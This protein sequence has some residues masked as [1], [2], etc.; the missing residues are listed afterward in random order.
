MKKYFMLIAVAAT[1][2][3]V[4]CKKAREVEN[5]T[6]QPGQTTAIDDSV[7]APVLFG[8]NMAAV[9]SP[10]MTKGVGAIDAW[11]GG[12][13]QPLYI[14][15][16]EKGTGENAAKHVATTWKGVGA[17]EPAADL[18]TPFIDNVAATAPN[19]G[20]GSRDA[21][22]V[23]NKWATGANAATEPYY[24]MENKIYDFYGYYVDDA[25][26]YTQA[27][28][29]AVIAPEPEIN[30]G[31]ALTEGAVINSIVL[32]DLTLNGTQDIMLAQ[33]D[34]DA[35]WSLRT[36]YVSLD[37]LYSAR[38]ARRN[39]H[40]DLV[41]KHL[42]SRFEFHVFD[43]GVNT[44]TVSKLNIAGLQLAKPG[45]S[46]KGTLTIYG[47]TPGFVATA[48]APT[49]DPAVPVAYF[50]LY[51]EAV[52]APVAGTAQNPVR[53]ASL[54][55]QGKAVV[56]PENKLGS[57]IMIAPGAET[58]ELKISLTQDDVTAPGY[59]P[60]EL[61]YDV[62][63]DEVIDAQGNKVNETTALA[64]KKYVVTLIVYSFE[65]VEITVTL[66]PWDEE[67]NIIIDPDADETDNRDEAVITSTA[68]ATIEVI[69]GK[70]LDVHGYFTSTNTFSP[71]EYAS[72][73]ESKFTV[74]E[75][76]VITGVAS[77]GEG[78][79]NLIVSQAQSVTHLAAEDV[80]VPVKVVADTRPALT[81]TAA[82]F[83]MPLRD[84]KGYYNTK[85]VKITKVE[86]GESD[87]TSS[88]VDANGK[89]KGDGDGLLVSFA[90]TT[91]D[92]YIKVDPKSGVVTAKAV[93][94]AVVTITIAEKNDAEGWVESTK[95][96]NVTIN[97]GLLPNSLAVAD[98]GNITLTEGA[99][100]S[101][102]AVITTDGEG[103]LTI[104]SVLES[105][106]ADDQKNFFSI[107]GETKKLVV[108]KYNEQTV[109]S[110]TY[111]VTVKAAGDAMHDEATRT[112]SVTI[113]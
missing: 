19:P 39:V 86:K 33:T 82:D 100:Q 27:E 102:A 106:S 79:V 1:V 48:A 87:I 77:T 4:S 13:Q 11:K 105:P 65:E 110:G 7:P 18:Y 16:L 50:D 90:V 57:S 38:A 70:T 46:D 107:N 66:T 67:G 101:D 113:Q 54:N 81:I 94:S 45:T 21:I 95:T 76:G 84:S 40:P 62:N 111:V 23:I 89:V 41:F 78:T 93:G 31:T 10:I 20:T 88:F 112:F 51:N 22:S 9:K 80:T 68:P 74:D 5:P 91:G 42:L 28:T 25:M 14:Y 83:A 60:M 75:N 30:G 53:P 72:A 24:Y 96:V 55:A 64:G 49:A 34:K 103:A 35:D 56:A 92:E 99:G 52:T 61:T 58:Y 15:G 17:G 109:P 37:M 26:G 73:D 32:N 71:I 12:N 85:R 29:P 108:A 47:E 43:G 59:N 8:S 3:T 98:A 63:M 69:V 44:P 36:E 104:E 6:Q 97:S 2:L